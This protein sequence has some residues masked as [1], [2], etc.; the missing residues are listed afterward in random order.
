MQL[1]QK[2]KRLARPRVLRPLLVCDARRWLQRGILRNTFT[3]W[4]ILWKYHIL[5]ATP[6]SLAP[7]YRDVAATESN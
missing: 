5:R 2:L 1:A 6:E 3:N 4:R 7:L